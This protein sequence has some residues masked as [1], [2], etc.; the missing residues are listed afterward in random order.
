M[1]AHIEDAETARVCPKWRVDTFKVFPGHQAS[2]RDA[3]IT[4]RGA[5][6]L[7]GNLGEARN[8]L[9]GELWLTEKKSAAGTS[10]PI[11]AVALEAAE[12]ANRTN[13]PPDRSPI[14]KHLGCAC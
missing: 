7:A 4:R 11:P 9:G 10:M 5:K 2:G 6:H 14:S 13:A 12:I 1:Q 8:L 3:Q